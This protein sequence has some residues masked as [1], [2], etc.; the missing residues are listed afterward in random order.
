MDEL[1]PGR[2]LLSVRSFSFDY[3]LLNLSYVY[4]SIMMTLDRTVIFKL[5]E[6]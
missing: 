6:F 2:Y 4:L 1:G 5:L 3:N